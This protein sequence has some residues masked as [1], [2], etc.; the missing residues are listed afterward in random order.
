MHFFEHLF[1]DQD[2]KKDFAVCGNFDIKN[3]LEKLKCV[4]YTDGSKMRLKLS[5]QRTFSR[6]LMEEGCLLQQ[7][8][9]K[10]PQENTFMIKRWV[11]FYCRCVLGCEWLKTFLFFFYGI[12]PSRTIKMQFWI[13]PVELFSVLPEPPQLRTDTVATIFLMSMECFI[14]IL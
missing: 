12:F 2:P 8:V 6:R 1:Q 5:E 11:A 10:N 14:N 4:N 9:E 13:Y 3:P 7:R